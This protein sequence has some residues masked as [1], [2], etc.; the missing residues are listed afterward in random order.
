MKR[1]LAIYQ[2]GSE[3]DRGNRS[4]LAIQLVPRRIHPAGYWGRGGAT[5]ASAGAAPAPIDFAPSNI[6]HQRLME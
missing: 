3:E 1:K 6:K 2:Y 5:I 4:G